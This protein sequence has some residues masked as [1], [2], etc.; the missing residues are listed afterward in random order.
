[1]Q[2]GV[3]VFLAYPAPKYFLLEWNRESHLSED[4]QLTL[5]LTPLTP[6]E[7]AYIPQVAIALMACTVNTVTLMVI[8]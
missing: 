4:T 1:M 7:T 5:S 8:A 3:N 2:L 6:Q